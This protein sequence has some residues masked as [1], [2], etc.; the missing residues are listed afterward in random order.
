VCS[1][2]RFLRG[3]P[4]YHCRVRLSIDE[5]ER[6]KALGIWAAGASVAL[7]AGPGAGGLPIAGVGWRS[8]FFVNLP[9][10]IFGIRLTWRY[11]EGSTQTRHRALDIAGQFIGMLAL[12]CLAV[13]MIEGGVLGWIACTRTRKLDAAKER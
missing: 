4:S 8:I 5:H 9:L 3:E 10:G 1:I 13:A 7:A 12:A 2:G 6:T 11:A